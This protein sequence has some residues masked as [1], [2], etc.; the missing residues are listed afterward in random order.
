[1]DGYAYWIDYRFGGTTS[2]TRRWI[3]TY[4]A[5]QADLDEL[6]RTTDGVV[7]FGYQTVPPPLV[8]GAADAPSTMRA[9]L[10]LFYAAERERIAGALGGHLD[11][12]RK[13]GMPRIP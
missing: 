5:F 9:A 7:A 8:P 2:I 1:M 6:R 10:R 3:E 13:K 11:H 4:E 12:R